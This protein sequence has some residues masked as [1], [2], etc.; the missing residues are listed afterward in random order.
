MK[1]ARKHDLM[2]I[3]VSKA[4]QWILSLFVFVVMID[5]TSTIL[6]L[7][8]FFFVAVMLLAFLDYKE[9]N[10]SRQIIIIV[11]FVIFMVCLSFTYGYL[12]DYQYDEGVRVGFIKSFLFV[13]LILITGNQKIEFFSHL[14]FPSIV[15][16]LVTIG[17]YVFFQINP[18]YMDVIY[19]DNADL[20]Q[21]QITII[22]S[23]RSF[24][25]MTITSIYYKTVPVL[26]LPLAYCFY[27]T[28]IEQKKKMANLLLSTIF[29]TALIFSGT[30]ANMVSAILV[31]ICVLMLKLIKSK[32]KNLQLLIVP[33][34]FAIAVSIFTL[35]YVMLSEKEEESIQ[36][37]GGH[38]E[39][40]ISLMGE[41]NDVLLFGQGAGGMFY[42]SG[43]GSMVS[44]TEITYLEFVRMYGVLGAMVIFILFTYPLIL[45]CKNKPPN[46]VPYIIG[47]MLYLFIGGTNPLLVGST[48]FI[49]LSTIYSCAQKQKKYIK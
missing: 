6:Q 17:W 10:L 38:L 44:R 13:F 30:R 41:N 11:L 33:L 49:V 15:I 36:T 1:I 24:M 28:V 4:A 47:Y 34:L 42:S 2:K 25:G 16:A 14:L 45:L 31:V 20:A 8:E 32:S 12:Q 3:T 22:M 35:L 46:Y 5:P 18:E 43:S 29:A 39:S 48:G 23:R 9:L 7:K 19:S 40:T 21:E 27:Q 26:I 37:K